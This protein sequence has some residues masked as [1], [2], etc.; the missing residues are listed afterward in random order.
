M[1]PLLPRETPPRC[2]RPVPPPALACPHPYPS[3]AARGGLRDVRAGGQVAKGDVYDAFRAINK[4]SVASLRQGNTEAD[5]DMSSLDWSE[6]QMVML[7]VGRLLGLPVTDQGCSPLFARDLREV[8]EMRDLLHQARRDYIN[9][10]I[11]AGEKVLLLAR[12]QMQEKDFDTAR[13][14]VVDA[15][16]V[17]PPPA[18]PYPSPDRPPFAAAASPSRGGPAAGVCQ[19]HRRQPAAHPSHQLSAVPPPTTFP[20]TQ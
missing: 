18:S 17:R 4:Q 8:E 20:P 19:D 1:Q 9:S 14:S 12:S 2:A 15:S 3:A 6:F 7:R 10:I 5:D 11:L 16:V 13:R